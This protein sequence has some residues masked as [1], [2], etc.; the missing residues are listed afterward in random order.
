MLFSIEYNIVCQDFYNEESQTEWQVH[1]SS[2]S[3]S[4]GIRSRDSRWKDRYGGRDP[5]SQ[6]WGGKVKQISVS[7]WPA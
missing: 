3:Q 7:L 5:S 1:G 6:H 4:C 2:F